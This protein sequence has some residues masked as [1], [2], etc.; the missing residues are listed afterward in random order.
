MAVE[1]QKGCCSSSFCFESGDHLY[2]LLFYV[3]NNLGKISLYC[4]FEDKIIFET[5]KRILFLMKDVCFHWLVTMECGLD[6]FKF[7]FAGD[8]FAAELCV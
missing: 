2:M 3:C 1:I 6:N 4:E 8:F 7:H 5:S